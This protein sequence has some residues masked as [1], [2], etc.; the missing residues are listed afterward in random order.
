MTWRLRIYEVLATPAHIWLWVCGC[1][2]G[3]KFSCGPVY[4]PD[5]PIG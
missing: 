5:D 4:D 2:C 1:L 3:Y